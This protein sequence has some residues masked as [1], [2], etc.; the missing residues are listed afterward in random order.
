MSEER[1][2]QDDLISEAPRAQRRR[3]PWGMMIV[4]GLFILTAFLSWWG[5]WF[6]RS[7]SDSQMQ[8]Y[9]HDS[10]K[11]RNVQ[12]ALSQIGDRILRGDE[13]VKQWYA[14]VIAASG[15]SVPEVRRMAAWVMG[16]DNKSG[17]FHSALVPMLGDDN[18][19]VRHNAALA[20]VRF[21]DEQARRVLVT[22][23]QPFTVRVEQGGTVELI[24]K[25]EGL[26]VLA[27]APLARIKQGEGVA[28]VRAPQE[29]R[30]EF[31]AVADKSE[32]QPGADLMRLSPSV[33]QVWE[34]LRGLYCIGRAEDA[35]H[36][37]RYTGPVPGMPDHIRKQAVATLEAIRNDPGKAR[38]NEQV[39]SK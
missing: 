35:E 23:L 29:G 10:E 39:A 7:L 33:D 36:I 24:F 19:A 14:E 8:E 15:H 11:P 20:L 5:S 30:I 31:I 25:E 6:G 34:A 4:A 26:P 12:H 28:E 21:N 2:N 9:L 17:E 38:C 18:A 37:Q 3:Y 22:M 1:K 16:Q 13:S 32:I 27:N